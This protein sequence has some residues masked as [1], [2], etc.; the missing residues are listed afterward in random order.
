MRARRSAPAGLIV[1]FVCIA[2]G[3]PPAEF[4]RGSM[5]RLRA[6]KWAEAVATAQE[7]AGHADATAT[8][9]AEALCLLA[10]ARARSGDS[11][12][13]EAALAEFDRA[14]GELSPEHW[15]F[16]EVE[17]LRRDLGDP[18]AP[19]PAAT[20]RA[21]AIDDAPTALWTVRLWNSERRYADAAALGERLLESDRLGVQ[22]RCDLLMHLAFAR[23]KLGDAAGADGAFAA[24][25]EA[26]VGLDA[27]DPL[28]AEMVELRVSLGL[29]P[30]ERLAAV[31]SV[32]VPPTE[33]TYW[34]F[35]PPADAGMDP[36]A[37]E[38][39]RTMCQR[40]AADGV[41]VAREGRIVLE[42]YSPLYR[43]PMMTM[44]SCKS[45]TGLLAGMLVARGALDIDAPAS[46][47]LPGWGEGL[48]GRVTVRHLL[49]MTA[50]L[51]R[52]P[53]VTERVDGEGWTG[54]ALKQQPAFEPGS[55]WEYT[56]EGAQLLSPI[57]ERAAE[58][59]LW[60]FARN[61]LFTPIGATG[62]AMRRDAAGATNT[63]AD[64]ET[65]LREFA[66]FGELVRRGGEWPGA[67]QVVP[68]PWIKTM[69]TPCPQAKDYGFLWWLSEAPRVWSMRGYLDTNVWVF[70]D[71]GVVVARVQSRAYLHATEA[72]D[73]GALERLVVA[74]CRR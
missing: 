50:G 60:E 12:G 49:T 13:A 23:V 24:F 68:K 5:E 59:P 4:I 14:S 9:R 58:R 51:P 48:R 70:P 28:R 53:S 35:G 26:A 57:L 27:S 46:N 67:G 17:R 30:L 61:E 33:D 65:K 40:S 71:Q 1:A 38:R 2:Q 45:I 72:F 74:A 15:V 29:A 22:G 25:A 47:Y 31:G 37:V 54:F 3:A 8:E 7:A 36:A 43:E 20:G 39:I 73:S 42:W 21:A 32:F 18:I 19:Q 63:Y 52:R 41:L 56:N 69:T 16:R 6:G 66:R 62:T 64:A 55:R 34:Q 10:V 11:S 44:S